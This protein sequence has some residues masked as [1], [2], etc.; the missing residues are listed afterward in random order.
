MVKNKYNRK[1]K[2]MKIKKNKTGAYALVPHKPTTD[3]YT[4]PSTKG[5]LNELKDAL[6]WPPEITRNVYGLKMQDLLK[7]HKEL[8]TSTTRMSPQEVIYK[9]IDLSGQF[10]NANKKYFEQEANKTASDQHAP[11]Q[12]PQPPAGPQL[13]QPTVPSVIKASPYG[14]KRTVLESKKKKLDIRRKLIKELKEEDLIE[15]YKKTYQ[16][17]KRTAQSIYKQ[18]RLAGRLK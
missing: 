6:V 9:S 2:R 18:L 12:I 16:E 15:K 3:P 10:Y 11:I 1:L 13:P 8:L 5:D 17:K 14:I 4:L 7:Q